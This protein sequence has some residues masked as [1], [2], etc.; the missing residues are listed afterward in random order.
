MVEYGR[1]LA[2]A[3]GVGL[4]YLQGD[5]AGGAQQIELDEP[6]DSAWCLLGSV[7]HLL[8]GPEFLAMLASVA[9][10]LVDGGTLVLELPHPRETF[11][12]DD[13]TR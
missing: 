7:G 3:A 5:M 4:R 2:S 11:R 13:V 8:T 9:S 1:G 12:L 6:V 10:C